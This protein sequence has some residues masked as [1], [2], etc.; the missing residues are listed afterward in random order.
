MPTSETLHV[1]LPILESGRYL[2][3]EGELF[4]VKESGYPGDV[5]DLHVLGPAS[6]MAATESGSVIYYN[7]QGWYAQP[8]QRGPALRGIDGDFAGGIVAVGDKGRVLR[9][10]GVG[11][12][13]QTSGTQKNLRDVVSLG[14][15]NAVAVGQYVILNWDGQTWIEEPYG[16]PKDLHSV[17]GLPSMDL[18]AVGEDGVVIK[19]D[20]QSLKWSAVNVSFLSTLRSVFGTANG[21]V[22]AVGDNGGCLIKK[23]DQEFSVQ[24]VPTK[25]HLRDVWGRSDTDIYAVGDRATVL[26]FN[27]SEWSIISENTIESSLRTIHGS[28]PGKELL[29]AMGTQSIHLGPFVGVARFESP[30]FGK[31]WDGHNLT[32]AIQPTGGAE[33]TFQTFRIYNASNALFWSI[34]APQWIQNFTLPDLAATAGVTM[35][36]AIKR[37]M[38]H[39]VLH[40]GFKI[41]EFDIRIYRL[42]DWRAWSISGFLFDNPSSVP[43]EPSEGM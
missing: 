25:Q 16:P 41:D 11:W 13:P 38:S 9:W 42:S 12:K 18:F 37:L 4:S 33:P 31:I 43:K 2:L 28:Q 29:L 39:R 17:W 34:I 27:G 20:P 32:W 24:E 36:K 6:A 30:T 3:A 8:V 26:H 10:N 40:S 5:L 19:R 1:D 22:I 7:G 23:G 21:F 14:T 15:A 35:P